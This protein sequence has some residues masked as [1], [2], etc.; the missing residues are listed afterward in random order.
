MN[1]QLIQGDLSQVMIAAVGTGLFVS[2]ASFTEPTTTQ[3]PTGNFTDPAYTA[4]SGLQNI[5]AMDAPQS[6]ARVS[7]EESRALSMV[8][9]MRYRHVLLNACYPTLKEAAGLG[10]RCTITD[11]NGSV[12]QYDLDGAEDDS[13][14]VMTRLRLQK[15]VL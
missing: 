14:A 11:A 2:L 15:V 10:W 8:E 9:S 3:G 1:Q 6:I 5:P 7:T 12:T 13:Q 4:V